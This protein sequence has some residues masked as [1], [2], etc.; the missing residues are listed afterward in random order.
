V[1]KQHLLGAMRMTP[2]SR[3]VSSFSIGLTMIG[4]DLAICGE[5]MA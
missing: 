1:P 3:I 4:G 5:L 2:S